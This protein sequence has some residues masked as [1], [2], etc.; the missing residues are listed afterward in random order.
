M[1]AHGYGDNIID[2]F[3][4]RMCQSYAYSNANITQ[5][6]D[7][8]SAAADDRNAGRLLEQF[9]TKVGYPLLIVETNITTHHRRIRQETMR[10][11]E[12]IR[13]RPY[14]H[15]LPI[16]TIDS[17][18]RRRHFVMT[19]GEYEWNETKI[20]DWLL[21]DPNIRS[22]SRIVYALDNYRSLLNRCASSDGRS[23]SCNITKIQLQRVFQDFCWALMHEHLPTNDGDDWQSLIEQLRALI[24]RDVLRLEHECACCIRADDQR[25][26]RACKW[27]WNEKCAKLSI[28]N[29]TKQQ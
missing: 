28:L 19:D 23:T 21:I 6:I 26:S 22:Y 1:L 16:D 17:G 27:I 8:M 9:F 25:Q 18:G 13:P 11:D 29:N 5:W 14:A 12:I 4:R 24:D 15:V 3:I 20:A 7:T 10:G 2:K